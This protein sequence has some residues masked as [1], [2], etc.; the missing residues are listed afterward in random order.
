MAGID[1]ESVLN[2]F[3]TDMKE[4]GKDPTWEN[5]MTWYTNKEWKKHL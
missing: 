1:F 2:L 5:F 3:K 4:Q